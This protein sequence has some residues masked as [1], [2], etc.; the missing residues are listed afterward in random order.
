M[1]RVEFELEPN[2]ISVGYI[3][4]E[5]IVNSQQDLIIYL[6]N[7]NGSPNENAPWC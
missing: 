7:A 1:N 6:D 5:S 2:N 4:D 3:V